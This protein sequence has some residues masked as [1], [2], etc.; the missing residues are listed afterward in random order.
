MWSEQ[1]TL[2]YYT[3]QY[4]IIIL[5]NFNISIEIRRSMVWSLNSWILI[6]SFRPCI[7]QFYSIKEF[8]QFT[9]FTHFSYLP[10]GLL[11]DSSNVDMPYVWFYFSQVVFHVIHLHTIM[12]SSQHTDIIIQNISSPCLPRV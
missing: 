7:I 10:S 11:S 5:N 2:L 3:L 4:S 8:L 12:V 1:Y 9:Y 6:R